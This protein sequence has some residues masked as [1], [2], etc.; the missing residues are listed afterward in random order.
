MVDFSVYAL[1]KANRTPQVDENNNVIREDIQPRRIIWKIKI[2]NDFLRRNPSHWSANSK[3]LM[4]TFF[5]INSLITTE[6][7][8]FELYI[9]RLPLPPP[10]PKK[11]IWIENSTFCPL[12]SK[13]FKLL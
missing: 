11:N 4:I 12:I 3:Y 7:F 2:I 13:H 8:Y 6:H 9:H 1:S 5:R 10:P